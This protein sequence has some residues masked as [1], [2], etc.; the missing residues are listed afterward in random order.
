MISANLPLTYRTTYLLY[1]QR[2]IAHRPD[3]FIYHAAPKFISPR[4]KPSTAV[5]PGA[6]LY[7]FPSLYLPPPPL[8][9]SHLHAHPPPSHRWSCTTH[10][11]FAARPHIPYVIYCYLTARLRHHMLSKTFTRLL[12]R[13]VVGGCAICAHMQC[14]DR[15]SWP[16]YITAS[17]TKTMRK[18][19]LTDILS[20]YRHTQFQSH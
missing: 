7:R 13:C 9:P 17:P 19:Y 14:F 1:S 2:T 6:G 20:F 5:L 10:C 3:L 12:S 11:Y 16:R 8:S 15:A 18:Y 4:I